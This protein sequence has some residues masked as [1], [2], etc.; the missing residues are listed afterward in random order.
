MSQRAKQSVPRGSAE[1]RTG[2][3]FLSGKVKFCQPKTRIKTSE[4]S[5]KGSPFP[6]VFRSIQAQPKKGA[7][8]AKVGN[9]EAGPNNKTQTIPKAI[10][11]KV[12]STLSVALVLQKRTRAVVANP[13]SN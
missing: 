13:V 7:M 5:N 2:K 10:D 11:R 6:Q 9:S 3:W 4:V 12:S 1:R 8:K